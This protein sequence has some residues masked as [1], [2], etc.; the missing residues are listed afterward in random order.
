MKSK[1]D[2]LGLALTFAFFGFV[3]GA[4]FGGDIV[5]SRYKT[6]LIESDKTF[7]AALGWQAP[8]DLKMCREMLT[9]VILSEDPEAALG[10]QLQVADTH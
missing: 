5:Q 1:L 3:G 4:Y 10:R 2:I 8:R 9:A 6:A 7:R